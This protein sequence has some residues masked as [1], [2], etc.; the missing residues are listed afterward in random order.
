MS[1][2]IETGF[3]GNTY[4]LTH[5]RVCWERRTGGTI[6]ATTEASGFAAVNAGNIRTDSA[7]RPTGTTL[8]RWERAFGNAQ[9]VSFLGIA[10]HDIGTQL[11]TVDVQVQ[12][13]GSG[14]WT[15]IA[16]SSTSPTDNNPLLFLFETVSV[17]A[18]RIRVSGLAAAPTIGVIACGVADEWPQR[19]RW[20]GTP[21]TEGDQ[22]SFENNVTNTGAWVGRSRR[23]DGLAF[24]LTMNHASETW[25][26]GDFADFKEYVNGDEAAF[27]IAS[28]PGKYPKEVSFAWPERVVTAER[29]MANATISTSVTLQCRGLRPA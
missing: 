10:K 7:W 15:T 12:L 22:T 25:R 1:V 23:S 27:F 14:T 29:A 19:F 9:N 8:E 28:W 13:A 16:G 4:P 6:S 17:D 3:T 24:E 2:V 26:A 11:G 21:I 20:T 5:G 18:I